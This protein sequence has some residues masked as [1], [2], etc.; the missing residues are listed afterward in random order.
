MRL[1]TLA[2]EKV[3]EGVAGGNDVAQVV[4]TAAAEGTTGAAALEGEGTTETDTDEGNASF[5]LRWRWRR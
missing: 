1:S 4:K 2:V 5:R 3:A